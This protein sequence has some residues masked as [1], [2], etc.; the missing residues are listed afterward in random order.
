MKWFKHDTDSLTDAKLRKVI[1]KYGVVGYAI[2]FHCLELIASEISETKLTFEL[3]HDAEIIADDLR[4]KGNGNQSGTEIVEE[5]MR[6]MVSLNLFD[7]SNGQI[8]CFKLLKRL[9]SSMTSNPKMRALINDAKNNHDTVMTKSDFIMQEKN[10]IEIE[11]NRI[12][13]NNIYIPEEKTEHLEEKSKKTKT[14]KHK[15]GEYKNVSLSDSEFDKLKTEH[16]EEK[17]NNI[18]NFFSELKE[19]KGYKYN[20]DYLAL[21]KWGISAYEQRDGPN[22]QKNY[23]AL[24]NVGKIE[25]EKFHDLK[26][27]DIVF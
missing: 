4:I 11:K 12:D 13:E 17:T 6:Y 20:S 2:Y 5:I 14:K 24:E 7:E 22:K 1:I 3:E 9:D 16:G 18:I 25:S 23:Y 21:K 15:Y 19:M 8:F 10:R 27:T 26:D